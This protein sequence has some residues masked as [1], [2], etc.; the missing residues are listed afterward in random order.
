MARNASAAHV[1]Q[2]IFDLPAIISALSAGLTLEAGDVIATGTP[3]GVGYAMQPPHYLQDGD[4]VV[5]RIDR[6][7]E[8]RNRIVQVK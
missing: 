4:I 5:S 2:M 3:S 8:L 1:S 7:G 6:I